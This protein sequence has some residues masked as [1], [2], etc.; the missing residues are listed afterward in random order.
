MQALFDDDRNASQR[1]LEQARA[2][3]RID[4]A[5]ARAA[6]ARLEGGAAARPAEAVAKDRFQRR[7]LPAARRVGEQWF[8]PGLSEDDP[9]VVRGA[10]VLLSEE[11]KSQ[12]RNEN[13]D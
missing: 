4:Q 9:V 5:Q 12:I 13:D 6:E 7:A 2:Q 1:Q 8:V 10:Q 11:L 3:A